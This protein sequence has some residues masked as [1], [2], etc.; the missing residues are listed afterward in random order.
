MT[1][2]RAWF[3]FLIAATSCS[4]WQREE[5][6]APFTFE[7]FLVESKTGCA[8]DTAACASF[9]VSYP[10]FDKLSNQVR[11]RVVE[12]INR[13]VAP[14]NASLQQAGDKF[15][16]DFQKFN[17]EMPESGM[18]WYYKASVTVLTYSDSLISLQAES[19]SFTGGAHGAHQIKFVN[20]HAKDGSPYVLS[21]FLK[22][23]FEEELSVLAEKAFRN[24]RDIS[25]N[26]SLE[27]AGFSFPNNEFSLTSNFGFRPEGI[28]FFYND[29]EVAAYAVGP[30]E[31]LI[32]YEE[33]GNW[34]K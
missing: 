19:E 7:T 33:L 21:D 1:N 26:V 34:I 6:V 2:A 17:A 8:A 31:I 22:P 14:D 27:E 10:V 20:V 24:A 15:I 9:E 32:P 16:T 4:S 18:G 29:Y 13:V 3:V 28:V 11:Q 30:T 25:A 5:K 23:G 12:E